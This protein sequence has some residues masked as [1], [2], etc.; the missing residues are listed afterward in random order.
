[1]ENT[2]NSEN[3]NE[4]L[5]NDKLNSR[6]YKALEIVMCIYLV[7]LLSVFIIPTDILDKC[8][9]C[10]SFTNFMKQFIPSIE[11]FGST[12]KIPQVVM[13]YSSY[14]WLIMILFLIILFL[15][16]IDE[17]EIEPIKF[18]KISTFFEILFL[19]FGLYYIVKIY[20]CGYL[21]LERQGMFAKH[22]Y[23][24]M[25][26]R[27]EILFWTFLINFLMFLETIFIANIFLIIANKT[28]K[29]IS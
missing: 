18:K 20:F 10:A 4:N 25:S 16:C 26:S 6:Y 11:I 24:T 17:F 12:S 19:L 3:K 13:F 2:E 22:F 14:M 28:K 27:P 7:L 21:V 9:I 5:Q 23:P 8:Q 1:M 15:Y 29:L